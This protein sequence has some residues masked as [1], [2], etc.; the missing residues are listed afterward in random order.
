MFGLSVGSSNRYCY[1]VKNFASH[2]YEY[3][4]CPEC[5]RTIAFPL[6]K[7]KEDTLMIEGGKLFPDFLS[8]G[9]SGVH[10]YVSSNVVR[11]FE[12]NAI[13]GFNV[14]K[15]IP[16]FRN[17]K[18]KNM[19]I[20]NVSY[21]SINIIGEIDLDLKFMN[22]KKKKLCNLC[23]QFDWNRQRL[24]ILDAKLDYDTWDKSDLCRLSS[25][26]G[27]IVSSDKVAELIKY[28]NL[29]GVY[30]QAEKDIFRIPMN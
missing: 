9:G 23:G 5:G 8:F 18:G 17:I 6:P 10:L 24:S 4:Q 11:I 7:D 15:C 12:A 2:G 16:I 28:H 22:L 20:S 21:Y 26:P 29:T 27:Y 3:R 14:D 30:L 1:A 19:L 25:F 13:S